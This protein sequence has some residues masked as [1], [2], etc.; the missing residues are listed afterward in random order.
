MNHIDEG[1]RQAAE[2]RALATEV[3]G[4]IGYT[5]DPPIT[6][7]DYRDAV[8]LHGPD[9]AALAIA[10]QQ[11]N[12]LRVAVHAAYPQGT[13]QVAYHL[14]DHDI[15][16][17][18]GR[19]AAA[20]ARQIQ[21]RLLPGY[22]TDLTTAAQALRQRDDAAQAREKVAAELVAA[23][24]GLRRGVD[25]HTRVT[26][27]YYGNAA[28]HVTVNGTVAISGHGDTVSVDLTGPTDL[29][30]PAFIAALTSND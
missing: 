7:A 8:R 19:G 28:T 16:V 14:P 9:S 10:R 27:S 5:V 2:L 21:R 15:T 6:D 20:I 22:L 4:L 12:P 23:V 29:L 17:A 11:N 24:P 3:A 1:W 26:L 30:L 13:S 18:I 25:S